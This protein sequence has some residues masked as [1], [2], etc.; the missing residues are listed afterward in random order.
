[1]LPGT[2][3]LELDRAGL[4]QI[5]AAVPEKFFGR[6]AV[7]DLVAVEVPALEQTFKARI[8]ELQAA[9]DPTSR[10]FLIKAVPDPAVELEPGLFARVWLASEPRPTLLVPASAIAER[11]QLTGVFVFEEERLRWRLV[12]TGRRVGER[13][14]IL[15]GL[16]PGERIVTDG[17]DR[18]RDG[19]RV[20][21]RP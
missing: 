17:V 12:R 15:A 3:L 1:V 21:P 18:A 20:E 5:R 6:L 14:E 13:V 19:A 11:G 7:G 9:A 4:R 8:T 16:H 10:T 2:P